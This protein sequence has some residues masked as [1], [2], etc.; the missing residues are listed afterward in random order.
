[1]KDKQ[2]KGFAI[3]ITGLPASG[4]STVAG[5]L[6]RLLDEVNARVQILETDE[7]RKILT[8]NPT[9]TEEERAVFYRSLAYI[10]KL[11]TDNGVS[12]IL[13]A[14]ANLKKYRDFGKELIQN[15][16]FAYLKCPLEFCLQR[17]PKGIYRRALRGEFKTVPGL[18]IPFEEPLD[19]GVVIEVDKIDAER[20]AVLIYERALEVFRLTQGDS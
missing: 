10:G 9:Y 12:V 14:T 18:Q 5:I 4:K 13:D 6:K 15:I 8:P 20:A 19:V 7:V 3:W 17:D 16:M 2:E 1:M 11:L